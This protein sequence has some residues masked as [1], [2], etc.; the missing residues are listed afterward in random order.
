MRL[1]HSTAPAPARASGLRFAAVLTALLAVLLPLVPAGPAAVAVVAAQ[2]PAPLSVPAPAPAAT[3]VPHPDTG[4]QPDDGCAS[5]CAAQ[6]RSRHDHLGERPAPQDRLPGTT[7]ATGA[8]PAAGGRTSAAST[9]LAVSPGRTSH[10]RG[11]A[12]PAHSGT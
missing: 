11:R 9:P 8:A 3:T 12:P 5:T 1:A 2:G 6:A 4:Y 7:H 10:D